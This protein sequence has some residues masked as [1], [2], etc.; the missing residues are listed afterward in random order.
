MDCTND[1]TKRRRGQHLTFEER[2]IIQTRWNDGWNNN[3]IAKE[4][5]C[6]Y[7][8]IKTEITRGM[9]P[10]YN[11]KVM[12]YKAHTGQMGY[13]L[14]RSKCVKGISLMNCIRFRCRIILLKNHYPQLKSIKDCAFYYDDVKIFVCFH[15]LEYCHHQDE[16]EQQIS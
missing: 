6:S 11:G 4:I 12:R 5:G 1:T 7:N 3:Q 9:T 16:L 10:L 13:E 2:V 15:I 14:N 8:C